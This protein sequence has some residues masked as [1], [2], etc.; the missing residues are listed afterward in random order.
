MRLFYAIIIIALSSATGFAQEAEFSI[1]KSVY[2][3]PK[4]NE[5][6]LLTH[7]FEVVNT[8]EEPLIIKDYKVGCSCTKL[9]I[10]SD[11]VLPGDTVLLTATFDTNGKYF[12][13]D[14]IITVFTNTK[15]GAHQL[16][17]KVSV[18]PKER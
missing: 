3:F 16:R 6:V 12:F 4:T 10:P 11:P 5:G 15:K 14:R 9:S 8:G 17:L 1:R 18:V 2:K 7:D 13:Q